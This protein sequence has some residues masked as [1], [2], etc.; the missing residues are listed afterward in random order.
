MKQTNKNS[1]KN[2]IIFFLSFFKILILI[3]IIKLELT[4]LLNRLE[5]PSSRLS[6]VVLTWED[7]REWASIDLIITGMTTSIV[8][9]ILLVPRSRHL[10]R[11]GGGSI[12]SPLRS[13]PSLGFFMHLGCPELSTLDTCL[14]IA[15]LT[16]ITI[17]VGVASVAVGEGES[18][19]DVVH[20]RVGELGGWVLGFLAFSSITEGEDGHITEGTSLD[21]DG[22]VVIFNHSQEF[23]RAS[24]VVTF[25]PDQHALGELRPS[26]DIRIATILLIEGFA[27]T[28]IPLE[29]SKN[30]ANKVLVGSHGATVGQDLN[31]GEMV[32]CCPF[33]RWILC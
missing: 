7:L 11:V 32:F 19:R 12:L 28:R 23:F 22:V 15:P 2:K 6:K 33:K 24:D 14:G 20:D 3:R 5:V 18:M 21:L 4:L 10:D 27:E 31:D 13:I 9:S 26:V 17:F 8:L 16:D 1:T 25:S 29:F 30:V